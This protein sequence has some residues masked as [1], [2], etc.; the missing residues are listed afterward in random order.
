MADYISDV[1]QGDK[2]TLTGNPTVL[3]VESK[4]VRQGVVFIT[5]RVDG[6]DEVG[7]LERF[8][9]TVIDRVA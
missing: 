9:R 6:S 8:E 7:T 1:E 5:Y 4:K 3:V 2:F